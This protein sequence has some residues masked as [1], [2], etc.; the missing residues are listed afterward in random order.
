[1]KYIKLSNISSVVIEA[2]ME[3]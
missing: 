3:G 2:E 1:M